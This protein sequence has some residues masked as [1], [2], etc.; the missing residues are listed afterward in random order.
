MEF[1][2]QTKRPKYTFWKKVVRTF[3]L[4]GLY[5]E[6]QHQ[7][8]DTDVK[9]W[10]TLEELSQPKENEI[11]RVKILGKRN[12]HA[13]R[14]RKGRRAQRKIKNFQWPW[15]PPAE[16]NANVGTVTNDLC[17]IERD[18]RLARKPE[19]KMPDT[20][21]RIMIERPNKNPITVT[22]DDEPP[23]PPGWIPLELKPD[24][25]RLSE[26]DERKLADARMNDWAQ[27]QVKYEERQQAEIEQRKVAI[28]KEQ[29]LRTL[30]EQEEKRQQEI[31]RAEQVRRYSPEVLKQRVQEEESRQALLS[32]EEQREERKAFRKYIWDPLMDRPEDYILAI[33]W[34]AY[35]NRDERRRK[36]QQEQAEKE[37]RQAEAQRQENLRRKAEEKVK[38]QEE[39]QE[40]QRLLEAQQEALRQEEER[41]KKEKEEHARHQ[42]KLLEERRH[43]EEAA[44]WQKE[45]ERLLR[46]AAKW[47]PLAQKAKETSRFQL[48]ILKLRASIP[49][50]IRDWRSRITWRYQNGK[51]IRINPPLP[52]FYPGLDYDLLV[53]RNAILK[54]E[55]LKYRDEDELMQF[56]RDERLDREK[57]LKR[58][59][60][61]KSLSF[62]ALW[63][64]YVYQIFRGTQRGKEIEAELKKRITQELP[65]S[66]S[67]EKD[68]FETWR[69]RDKYRRHDVGTEVFNLM[70][71]RYKKM[72]S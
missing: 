21:P 64:E 24:L 1:D 58:A 59:I 27:D 7:I 72:K 68:D 3:G 28:A 71:A 30:K 29:E 63:D 35:R 43:Q 33:R 49:D 36:E 5:W 50:E 32:E 46:A 61:P 67:G 45:E 55:M 20:R 16:H 40:R 18:Q 62:E 53:A 41:R 54:K 14:P 39:H 70:R 65:R 22:R 56:E 2:T 8:I 4:K 17:Q 23:R 6:W 51:A 57:N 13:N 69:W 9:R 52:P 60:C 26:Q 25:I 66:V 31:I 12:K 11:Y 38:R 15:R 48:Q 34:C 44:L 19:M 37:A 47:I 42:A 10:A